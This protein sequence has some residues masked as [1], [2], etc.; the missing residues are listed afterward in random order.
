MVELNASSRISAVIA[1]VP[2]VGWLYAFLLQRKNVFA[3]FHARQSLGLFLFLLAVFVGW[4]VVGWLLGWL[5]YGFLFTTAL[6]ALVVVAGVFSVFAW[7]S[8][9]LN[10]AQGRVT[11]LPIFGKRA[12]KL[13]L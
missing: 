1:Y 13:P 10:A 4:A 2:V 9:V 11:L 12:N 3:R 8:G 5:P 6:F 7:V